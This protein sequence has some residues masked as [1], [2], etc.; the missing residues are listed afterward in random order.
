[1][2]TFEIAGHE[3]SLLPDG[4]W[5]LVWS[6]EFDGTSL[7]RTKW[8]FRL[9]MMGL[10]HPAWVDRGVRLDGKRAFPR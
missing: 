7:A 3:P 8:D 4:A 2:K 10:R 5:K 6:D 1:M 9:S